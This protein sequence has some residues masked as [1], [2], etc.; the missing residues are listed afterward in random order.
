MLAKS[1]QAGKVCSIRGTV[2]SIPT[3]CRKYWVKLV[4]RLLRTLPPVAIWMLALTAVLI[5]RPEQPHASARGAPQAEFHRVRN[6][7]SWTS[8]AAYYVVP[9]EDIWRANGVTNPSLLKKG[10]RIL[11]PSVGRGARGDVLRFEITGQTSIWL[12][13][14]KSGNLLSS[15]LTL[16]GLNSPL[17]AYGQRICAPNRQ[18]KIP[19][20]GSTEIPTPQPTAV[21]PTP[22][23]TS[24]PA[25]EGALM[26]SKLGIQGHFLLDDQQRAYLLDMVAYDL[27]FGWVKQQVKWEEFEYA[28]GK[29]SDVMLEALDLFVD[30]AYNRNLRVMLSI[31]KAPDW[32]R[33]TTEEDG[34]PVDYN[35]YYEFIKF[36][37]QR[38]KFKLNAVEI[39]NEPNLGREWRGAPLS[40][41]EYVRLLAGAYQTVKSAYPEGNI[42]V[43]SAGLAPT[44][45]NDGINAVDDRS[46][47]RQMYQAGLANY[48]D[49]IG[50]HPYSWGNPPWTRCCGDWGGAPSHNDHPTFFFLNTIEDY[51]AIQAEFGDSARPLWATEFG[52]GTMDGLDRPVPPDAPFFN[53]VNQDQQAQYILEAYR[54]GQAWDF[55][56]PMFLW[57]FN[58]S[59]LPGGDDNQSGYS[60]L[61][62]LERP[63]QAYKVLRDSPKVDR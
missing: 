22:S 53:Y 5:L 42:V 49:A 26:R 47:L 30:D 52:W 43:V 40:G 33:S 10:Q 48:A 14:L 63:R 36:I 8:I 56:G 62:T 54:M 31:A 38:Y 16:N 21:P 23:P 57:N 13:A 28:P 6:N 59:T 4:S 19:I 51:R 7:D 29:Y 15:L 20:A 12:A 46:Y 17:E 39:W 9:V 32:A 37:V 58:I 1:A 45:I 27:G 50:I 3:S 2:F 60:I 55:M 61:A 24:T 25:S 34:P 35:A 11:I 41:S 18:H 44:G